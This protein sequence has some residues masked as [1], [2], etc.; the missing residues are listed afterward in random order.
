MA[1]VKMVKGNAT[2]EPDAKDV[3]VWELQGWQVVDNPSSPSVID[4]QPLDDEPSGNNDPE[5]D[6]SD[7]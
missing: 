7:G 3:P 6:L 1:K 4:E 2:A 5:G